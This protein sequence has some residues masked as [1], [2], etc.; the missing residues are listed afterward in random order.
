M[1]TSGQ[2]LSLLSTAQP[3]MLSIQFSN[4]RLDHV[5]VVNRTQI[6]HQEIIL[7]FLLHLPTH[8]NSNNNKPQYMAFTKKKSS[9]EINSLLGKFDFWHICPLARFNFWHKQSCNAL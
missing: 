7:Y 4:T 9:H 2:N 1:K 8:L 5:I 3:E 6:I